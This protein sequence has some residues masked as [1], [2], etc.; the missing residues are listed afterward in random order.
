MRVDGGGDAAPR[1]AAAEFADLSDNELLTREAEL[2]Q[3]RVT[4][5]DE[6]QRLFSERRNS[7]REKSRRGLFLPPLHDDD[8][9]S[10]ALPRERPDAALAKSKKRRQQRP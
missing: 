3:R 1:A 5:R 6:R 2:E 4:V 10:D 7:K 8:A 9:D